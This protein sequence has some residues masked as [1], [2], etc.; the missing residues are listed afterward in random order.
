MQTAGLGVLEDAGEASSHPLSKIPPPH[1][2]MTQPWAS[3][4]L[5]NSA[6]VS[7]WEKQLLAG[8]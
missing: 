2:H 4:A 7:V 6:G 8:G 1:S 5:D 3:R